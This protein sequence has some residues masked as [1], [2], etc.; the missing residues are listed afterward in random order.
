MPNSLHH[1]HPLAEESS[2]VLVI[3]ITSLDIDILESIC[4]GNFKKKTTV[5]GFCRH[6]K[7]FLILR[8]PGP[9]KLDQNREK[10]LLIWWDFK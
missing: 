1:L 8:T 9:G 7:K 3:V 6:A 10:A 5:L 2:F 4:S